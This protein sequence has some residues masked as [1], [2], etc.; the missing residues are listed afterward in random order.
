MD[1]KQVEYF[2]LCGMRICLTQVGD[3]Y[4]V[5]ALIN[6]RAMLTPPLSCEQSLDI[7]DMCVN[8]V[9]QAVN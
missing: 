9:R 8:Q 6:G 2:A 7:F 4:F 3:Q 5:A 1:S